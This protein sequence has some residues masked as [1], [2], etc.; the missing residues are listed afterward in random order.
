MLSE[1]NAIVWEA[2]MTP[3]NTS[4]KV[5][6]VIRCVMRTNFCRDDGLK[7]KR[8]KKLCSSWRYP[9]P[10][11]AVNRALDS[12]TDYSL[13]NVMYLTLCIA[14]STPKMVTSCSFKWRYKPYPLQ[15]PQ[16]KQVVGCWH[17]IWGGEFYFSGAHETCIILVVVLNLEP[18][19]VLL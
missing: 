8:R 14:L 10:S 1:E 13:Q 4:I 15:A 9:F 16:R 6:P 5:K 11:S 12:A 17:G 18:L 3:Q 19:F 2:W 7:L